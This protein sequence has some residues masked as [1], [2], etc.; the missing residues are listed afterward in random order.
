MRPGKQCHIS[1]NTSNWWTFC[2]GCWNGRKCSNSDCWATLW[3]NSGQGEENLLL[4]RS[5]KRKTL[6]PWITT[7]VWLSCVADHFSSFQRVSGTPEIIN[8]LSSCVGAQEMNIGWFFTNLTYAEWVIICTLRHSIN[9]S[10]KSQPTVNGLWALELSKSKNPALLPT[11]GSKKLFSL[12][13]SVMAITGTKQTTPCLWVCH[14][15]LKSQKV[16]TETTVF[17]PWKMNF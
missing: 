15:T 6:I 2:E 17:V 13:Y 5:D 1:A 12:G 3:A 4:T 7:S 8:G 14:I 10:F 9:G 16:F 11:G